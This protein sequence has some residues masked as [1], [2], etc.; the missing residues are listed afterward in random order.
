MHD[1]VAVRLP[2]VAN[3]SDILSP[4]REHSEELQPLLACL[5]GADYN[6]GGQWRIQQQMMLQCTHLCDMLD[7][8]QVQH[9][10][11][12]SNSFNAAAS[13]TVCLSQE[14]NNTVIL[15]HLQ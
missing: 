4:I 13:K 14:S 1:S 12:L 7:N 3:L 6:C 5:A 10:H 11:Q 9:D 8:T 15:A 2:L